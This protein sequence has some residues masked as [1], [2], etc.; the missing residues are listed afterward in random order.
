V[1]KTEGT[2][3]K[4]LFPQSFPL[5]AAAFLNGEAFLFFPCAGRDFER[6]SLSGF[7]SCADGGTGDI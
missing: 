4:P 3:A 7:M 2:K 6:R 1:K 5:R